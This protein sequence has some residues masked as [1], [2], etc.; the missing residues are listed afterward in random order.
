MRSL[1][2]LLLA[3]FFLLGGCLD[4]SLDSTTASKEELQTEG[5][6][7]PAG[8]ALLL[9][10]APLEDYDEVNLQLL[11]ISL[12]ADESFDSADEVLL[13]EGN[14]TVNLLD[15]RHHAELFSF[16]DEVPEGDY[17]LVRLYSGQ[18]V[19]LV[20]Y[21]DEGGRQVEQARLEYDFID[22]VTATPITATGGEVTYL[23]VDI[24]LEMSLLSYDEATDTLYF[25][26]TVSARTLEEI[27]DSEAGTTPGE[28][29][30]PL[31]SVRGQLREEQLI[32][33]SAQAAQAACTHLA[34]DEQ[35]QIYDADLALISADQLPLGSSVIAMGRLT[36]SSDVSARRTL[37]TYTLV[38]G[39]RPQLNIR[40]L[41]V[42]EIQGE[43]SIVLAN[44]RTADWA[45][46]AQ[47]ITQDGQPLALDDLAPPFQASVLGR[48][49]P[50]A[51]ES[52][53]LMVVQ[54]EPLA[55]DD[56]EASQGSASTQLVRAEF[57]QVLDP[58]I[59]V[60]QVIYQGEAL[61]VEAAQARQVVTG[62]G[63]ISSNDSEQAPNNLDQGARI[64]LKGVFRESEGE[65][66]AGRTLV[67]EHLVLHR[68]PAQR[69]AELPKGSRQR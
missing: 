69:R 48:F 50:G 11:A 51:L 68:L 8:V 59:P 37:Q 47:I 18:E 66:T 25:E 61:R 65:D 63:R 36:D 1:L 2:P 3:G 38:A 4:S 52:I 43:E 62:S 19:E 45:E 35:T 41:R 9:T 31:I 57:D 33:P 54:D 5:S 6:A 15:L 24:D 56:E 28:S 12:L 16:S 32:C 44:G 67:V 30:Q 21:D 14:Q 27:E 53:A 49:S 29:R 46:K 17:T 64:T 7:E 39:Q 58:E 22:L 34:Q 26:P 10:D 40:S 42:S 20:T 23:E 60:Y 13:F 55:S